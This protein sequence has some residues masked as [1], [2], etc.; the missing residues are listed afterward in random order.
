MRFTN[1]Y[2]TIVLSAFIAHPMPVLP[3]DNDTREVYGSMSCEITGQQ[4][5]QSDEGK[6]IEYSNVKGM[7]TGETI[8]LLYRAEVE[9]SSKY[10]FAF[11]SLGS[12][13]VQ[14]SSIL[15]EHYGDEDSFDLYEMSS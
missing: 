9:P 8:P 6:S 14:S 11:I 3:Q 10:A 1:L 7:E 13:M 2:P 4:V 5:I 15:N 12:L